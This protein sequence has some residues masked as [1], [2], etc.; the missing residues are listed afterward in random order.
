MENKRIWGFP[1]DSNH[2]ELVPEACR[3]NCQARTTPKISRLPETIILKTG[4]SNATWI[5]WKFQNV[6]IE[7]CFQ[8][9]AKLMPKCP[10]PLNQDGRTNQDNELCAKRCHLPAIC[11]MRSSYVKVNLELVTLSNKLR[12]V[13]M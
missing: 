1:V 8:I 5:F 3:H 6:L 2:S 12:K 10:L 7:N 11:Q 4:K 13:K 9:F